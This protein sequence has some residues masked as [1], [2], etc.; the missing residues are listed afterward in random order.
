MK[1]REWL[2]GEW[3]YYVDSSHLLS[4]IPYCVEIADP[5]VLETFNELCEY[6]R[7]L[8][9]QFQS[10]GV[11]P[12]ENQCEAYGHYIL[13]LL[14]RDVEKHL[15]YFRRQIAEL[16][17]EVVGDAPARALVRLLVSLNRPAEALA[18]VLDSVFEDELYGAPV[19]S[20]LNLCYQA[21]DFAKLKDL[22]Q[23]RGD[24]LSYAAGSI[25]SR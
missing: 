17:A 2:F 11:P 4:V 24:L 14:G 13:A 5:P 21:K 7:H 18:V 9:P 16:D 25:L 3:D 12:F 15:D 23:E 19:P 8:A 10:A 6:G 22:A 1:G 20:A